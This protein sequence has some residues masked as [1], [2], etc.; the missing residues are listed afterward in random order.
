MCVC[1]W[2]SSYISVLDLFLIAITKY[3]T[4]AITDNELTLDHSLSGYSLSRRERHCRGKFQLVT[5]VLPQGAEI[6]PE[7]G[8]ASKP[9]L[10]TL[11]PLAIIYLLIVTQPSTKGQQLWNT[12]M[13]IHMG[14]LERFQIQTK[15][16]NI[17]I[18]RTYTISF[19][20]LQ[21]LDC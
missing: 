13:S 6:G 1:V 7:V 12:L 5:Q 14:L 10:S 16:I 4:V 15:M 20:C 9:A 21:V 3:S 18:Y 17:I 2:I 11:L 19:K 8:L